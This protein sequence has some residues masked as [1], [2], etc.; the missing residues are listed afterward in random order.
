MTDPEGDI[1]PILEAASE[2]A[3][4]RIG[5]NDDHEESSFN[6][7]DEEDIPVCYRDFFLV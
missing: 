6:L 1:P 3:S 5:V 2:W 4:F 7:R